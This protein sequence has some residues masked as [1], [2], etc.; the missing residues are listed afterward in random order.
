MSEE[1][2]DYRSYLLRLW[3]VGEIEGM[4]WRASIQSVQGGER[5]GFAGLEGLF[6]FLRR[7]VLEPPSDDAEEN[8]DLGRGAR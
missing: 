6:D 5:Q 4:E 1:K 3:K 8:G 7:Q 2:P